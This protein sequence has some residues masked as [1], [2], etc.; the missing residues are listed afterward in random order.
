MLVMLAYAEHA[1]HCTVI[2]HFAAGVEM[3]RKRNLSLA[4]MHGSWES[5]NHI[6]DIL[7]RACHQHFFHS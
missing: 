2:R 6:G 3:K 7:A 5:S 4:I 1:D